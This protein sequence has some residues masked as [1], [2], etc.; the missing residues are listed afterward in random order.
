MACLSEVVVATDSAEVVAVCE[1]VGARAVLTDPGHP[2][3]TDR[4]AEVAAREGFSSWEVVVNLQGDEP[5]MEAEPVAAAVQEVRAGRPIGTC[6]TPILDPDD[7]GDPGVVK[8]VLRDDGTAL[9]FSRAPIPFRRDGQMDGAFLHRKPALRHLGVYAYRR[10][11]L[12][13]WVSLP[14]SRLEVIERLEQL[15]ALEAGM[16]IGVAVVRK[17]EGGV[18]TLAD[19]R[20]IEQRM[21]ELGLGS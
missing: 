13:E 2:S 9:Y 3:G 1:G 11:A 4:V 12:M 16:S 19:A 21:R 15:R 5:L 14:P 18:D 7:L 10:E 20:R 8:V 6:A 17:A